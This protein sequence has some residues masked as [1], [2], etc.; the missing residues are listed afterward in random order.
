M[1]LVLGLSL[2]GTSLTSLSLLQDNWAAVTNAMHVFNDAVGFGVQP[3]RYILDINVAP[4]RWL[5]SSDCGIAVSDLRLAASAEAAE[6][7]WHVGT[8][9]GCQ[10]ID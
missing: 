7:G 3:V 4:A 9:L 2:S 8:T 10:P 5:S 6:S 1:P